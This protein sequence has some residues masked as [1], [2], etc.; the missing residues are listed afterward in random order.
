M[1]ERLSEANRPSLAAIDCIGPM[2][3]RMSPSQE[4]VFLFDVDNTLLDNDGVQDDLKGHLEHEFGAGPGTA[5]SPSWKTCMPNSGMWTTWAP[6][7]AIGSRICAI[8]GC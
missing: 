3:D 1:T 2:G 4:V 8:R 7:S 6:Y 5:I